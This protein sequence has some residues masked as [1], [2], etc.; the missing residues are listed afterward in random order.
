MEKDTI[1]TL[2][3]NTNYV[4]LD[5]MN[6]DGKKYFFAVRLDN[7]TNNPTMEYGY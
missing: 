5:E 1:I 3:D 6:I 2:E 4:L 7:E